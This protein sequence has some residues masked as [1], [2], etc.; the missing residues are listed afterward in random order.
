MGCA[1]RYDREGS[2]WRLLRPRG[3]GASPRL[4]HAALSWDRGYID[5]CMES[6]RRRNLAWSL[7]GLT[8]SFVAVQEIRS[9]L[10][11]LGALLVALGHGDCSRDL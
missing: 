3:D 11:A 10:A 9:R 5:R 4:A 7:K 1:R 2:A 8:D 6:E